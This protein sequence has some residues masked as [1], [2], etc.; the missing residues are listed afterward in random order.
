MKTTN[1]KEINL[2][3]YNLKVNH[4]GIA[5]LHNGDNACPC[6]FKQPVPTQNKFNQNTMQ[7]QYL[8]CS[9]EC[10]LMTFKENENDKNTIFVRLGCSR[11][12]TIHLCKLK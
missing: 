5:V 1:K 12:P 11:Q 8:A 2:N 3:D 4:I 7:I 6:P 10:P 9:N